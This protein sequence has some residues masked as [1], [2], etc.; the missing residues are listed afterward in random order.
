MVNGNSSVIIVA[1]LQLPLF[2]GNVSK[3]EDIIGSLSKQHFWA[4]DGSEHFMCKQSGLSQIF[5]LIVSASEKIL[6]NINVAVWR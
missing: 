3:N 1:S 2:T 4:T 5:K 6:D